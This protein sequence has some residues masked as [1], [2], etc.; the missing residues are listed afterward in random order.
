MERNTGSSAWQSSPEQDWEDDKSTSPYLP[1]DQD[2]QSPDDPSP[3]S[4]AHDNEWLSS[5]EPE[6]DDGQSPDDPSPASSA[7]DNEWLSS[8]EPENDDGQPDE[9]FRTTLQ[10]DEWDWQESP[11]PPSSESDNLPERHYPDNVREV[12]DEDAPPHRGFRGPTYPPR[13]QGHQDG[14]S[15]SRS[16]KPEPRR[17]PRSGRGVYKPAEPQTELEH[18][19]ASPASESSS[20]DEQIYYREVVASAENYQHI[21][22]PYGARVTRNTTT[23]VDIFLP[24]GETMSSMFN[25]PRESR[26]ALRGREEA[27]CMPVELEATTDDRTSNRQPEAANYTR[28][29]R[30]DSSQSQPRRN[31][32]PETVQRPTWEPATSDEEDNRPLFRRRYSRAPTNATTSEAAPAEWV[33]APTGWKVDTKDR[34]VPQDLVEDVMS[35]MHKRTRAR[36]SKELDGQRFQVERTKTRRVLIHL[37]PRRKE[38]M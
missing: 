26:Q 33:V 17:A 20:D 34:K 15:Y 6:N 25:V 11:P 8:S 21:T 22:T 36:Y 35:G 7:Y 12:Y 18:Y 14:G 28:N 5:S 24:P 31:T 4:S 19:A 23:T 32:S 30:N 2:G 38:R 1:Q 10:R 13:F 9:R 27:R 3:A 29:N 37:T 16:P